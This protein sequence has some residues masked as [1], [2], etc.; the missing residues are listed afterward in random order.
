M[1]SSSGPVLG[2]LLVGLALVGCHVGAP[3]EPERA[4]LH[5]VSVRPADGAGTDCDPDD[6]RCGVSPWA[7]IELALDRFLR[8]DTAVRQSV[9]LISGSQATPLLEPE[10]DLVER[11]LRYRVPTEA[12]LLPG[13]LYTVEVLL[14]EE[15]PRGFG[16]RAFDGA[17]LRPGSVPLRFHFRTARAADP[18]P[19]QELAPSCEELAGVLERG[20][21]GSTGCHRNPEA[22][23]GLSLASVDELATQTVGRV[24][25]QTETG[26][27][28]GRPLRNPARWGTQ[29]PL[30][31]SGEPANSYLFYKLLLLPENLR[32]ENDPEP[33]CE[34]DPSDP[35]LCAMPP[36]EEQRRLADW[37]VRGTGMPAGNRV[38]RREDLRIV[39]TWIRAGVTCR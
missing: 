38:L 4:P 37:F 39:Q 19:I 36:D 2:A 21:C 28:V 11:V 9:R 34:T 6:D 23:M 15:D 29:M 12:P 24:A 18:P 10:Y 35:A 14:P 17:P 13:T 31:E 16:L 27:R 30:I 8:P 1:S 26:P 7:T 32:S 3:S 20:G 33:A 22:A 25:R 5:V